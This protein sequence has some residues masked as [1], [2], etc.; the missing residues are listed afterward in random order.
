VTPRCS[1][2]LAVT[3]ALA[4]CMVG[5]DY[6]P[7]D[8]YVPARW[9]EAP[10]QDVPMA[11]APSRWWQAF[12]DPK[13]DAL[14]ER[15]VAANLDLAV[16]Q[17]RV[18]EARAERRVAAAPLF[19]F[20]DGSASL[21]RNWQSENAGFT[22]GGPV[23]EVGGQPFDLYDVGFDA[24]WEIDVFGG[25]RRS[26]EA[27]DA[28][29]EASLEERNDVLL[30]LLGEVARDYVEL[31]GFQRELAVTRS[32]I[33]VQ[34]DT[35]GLT[36]ARYQGG[37]ASDLDVARAEAQV[38]TTAAQ[39]PTL[40][41]SVKQAVHRLGVLLGETPGALAADLEPPAPIPAGPPGLPPGLPS[42]L[43]RRRPDVRRAERE[44]A[45]ATARIGVA[46]A[47][48]FPRFFLTGAAGLQS[49][50]AS[51]LFSGGSK[52]WSIGPTMQWPVF[53][54][55]R[56]VGNIEVREAQ[57]QQA[58]LGYRQR[59]LTALEEAENAIVAYTRERERRATLAA[60]VDAN[61]R[62]VELATELY[63]RGLTD[64]LDVLAAQGNLFLTQT[65]LARS[66]AAVSASLVALNKALG[67]GWEA[68]EA[69]ERSGDAWTA[70]AAAPRSAGAS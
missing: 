49:L 7:P 50:D 34:E 36:R 6:R 19:P 10:Q 51:D 4:G 39:V 3:L 63:R 14:V 53:Q 64:F 8:P 46:T 15:A 22:G 68:F 40:E 45:A 55:G 5:P 70:R 29:L 61:Q 18:R 20:L 58:L 31:R 38:R 54:G 56:I 62:A 30:T 37:L 2:S 47:D 52:S 12:G 28:E 57:E 43:V 25:V 69:G 21:S 59:I 42:D 67:G 48:L 41:T 60:A 24:S 17:A 9:S 32:N 33:A 26:V 1:L 35:L 11:E 23:G 27:A 44:V 66:D 65:D 13:L 16:A